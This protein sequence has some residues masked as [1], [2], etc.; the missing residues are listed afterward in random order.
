MSYLEPAQEDAIKELFNIS[1]GQVI[2]TLSSMLDAEISFSV[3]E[4]QMV[5]TVA[6]QQWLM[7]C[8]TGERDVV[9]MPYGLRFADD[10][11]TLGGLA[12]LVVPKPSLSPLLNLL[13][14]EEAT[15]ENFLA[16]QRET[17]QEVSD[18]LLYTCASNMSR[19]LS[20]EIESGEA[21]TLSGCNDEIRNLAD[22][23]NPV[24]A[25]LQVQFHLAQHGEVKGTLVFFLDLGKSPSLQQELHRLLTGM[26]NSDAEDG[27]QPLADW[28][29]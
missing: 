7:E 22:G 6:L 23:L 14:G 1:I 19:F 9:V 15:R 29:G 17:F 4:F 5:D 2:A 13:W 16:R 27:S 20:T 25:E 21:H 24:L 10:Q 8:T 11:N 28:Q 12:M 3:P 26:N 18:L